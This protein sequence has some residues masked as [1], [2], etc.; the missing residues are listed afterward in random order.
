METKRDLVEKIVKLER[1]VISL[2]MGLNKGECVKLEDDNARF[3]VGNKTY[4]ASL[5]D[6]VVGLTIDEGKMIIE[7]VSSNKILLIGHK[8]K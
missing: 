5:Q 4:R 8:L 2:Q 6:G 1:E 3:S 7:S